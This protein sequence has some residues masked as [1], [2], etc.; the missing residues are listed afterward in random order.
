MN[1]LR[2]PLCKGFASKV[3]S[4]QVEHDTLLFIDRSTKLVIINHEGIFHRSMPDSLVAIDERMV[5]NQEKQSAAALL[6]ISG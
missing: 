2:H 3:S 4:G 6:A 5:E 1:V